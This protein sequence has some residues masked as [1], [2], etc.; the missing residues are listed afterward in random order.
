M[1]LAENTKNEPQFI[2]RA[3]AAQ[4]VGHA[5][6][7]L[8]ILLFLGYVISIQDIP[9]IARWFP[10]LRPSERMINVLAIV[11]LGLIP[12]LSWLSGFFQRRVIRRWISRPR[13]WMLASVA[14]FWV[15]LIAGMRLI[16]LLNG[17]SVAVLIRY[18][19][20]SLSEPVSSS[21]LL[22]ARMVVNGALAGL[23]CGFIFGIVQSGGLYK[24]RWLW[25][26]T[27]SAFWLLFFAAANPLLIFLFNKLSL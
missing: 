18:N 2:R 23:A 13:L 27:T 8:I 9:D 20:I 16:D 21:V 11:L 17:P 4:L 12:P 3:L 10:A 22:Y 6:I 1:V 19:D 15:L 25:I 7:W 5:G 24:G 14:A 26:L